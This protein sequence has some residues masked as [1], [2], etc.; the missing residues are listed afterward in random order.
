MPII[1]SHYAL[2]DADYGTSF[3]I[4]NSK[5]LGLKNSVTK[6]FAICN[7]SVLC[8]ILLHIARIVQGIRQPTISIVYMYT[9][10]CQFLFSRYTIRV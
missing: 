10:H 8:T 5:A 9:T 7:L 1:L 6:G 2:A 3:I 4:A